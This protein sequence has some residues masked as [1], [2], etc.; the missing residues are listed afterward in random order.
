MPRS[1]R[2]RAWLLISAATLLIAACSSAAQSAAE[3]QPRPWDEPVDGTV[4]VTAWQDDGEPTS[5]FGPGG[6]PWDSPEQL[7]D[8]MAAA[9]ASGGGLEATGSVVERRADDTAVGWVRGRL[10]EAGDEATIAFDLRLELRR[11]AG[12]WAV[13]VS[14]SREHCARELTAGSCR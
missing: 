9:L 8:A 1:P 4:A 10:L 3:A 6:F 13:A 2:P 12:A 7:V 5:P 11:E 14:R